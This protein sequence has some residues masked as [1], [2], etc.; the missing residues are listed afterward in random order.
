MC[1]I[2]FVSRW[3]SQVILVIVSSV[4]YLC[5]VPRNSSGLLNEQGHTTLG[6]SIS[7]KLNSNRKKLFINAYRHYWTIHMSYQLSVRSRDWI[8]AKFFFACLWTETQSKSTNTQ[9]KNEANIQSL[10]QTSYVNKGFTN[11]KRTLRVFGYGT[12]G[13]RVIPLG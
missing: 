4:I 6:D 11:R 13:K 7:T 3:N 8:S 2:Y 1:P 10:D 12:A 5:Y 9:G